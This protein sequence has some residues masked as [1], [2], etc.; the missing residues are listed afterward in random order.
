M[1]QLDVSRKWPRD[2]LLEPLRNKRRLAAL[3]AWPDSLI[4]GYANALAAHD[5]RGEIF[6]NYKIG[7]FSG[8]VSGQQGY[9][10]YRREALKALVKAFNI[11]ENERTNTPP[12]SISLLLTWPHMFGSEICIHFTEVHESSFTPEAHES[13]QNK[14]PLKLNGTY[15]EFS[16]PIKSPFEAMNLPLPEGLDI[17][18]FHTRYINEDGVEE[19]YE[20]WSLMRSGDRLAKQS[21]KKREN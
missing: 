14:I 20:M 17:G 18:G 3:Q 7:C 5:Q 16:A 9:P 19:N 8:I 21:F 1:R 4:G 6:W 10:D 2:I 12:S 11:L 13:A 15:S